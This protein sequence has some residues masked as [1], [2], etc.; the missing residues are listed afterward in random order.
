MVE[1]ITAEGRVA[2]PPVPVGYRDR[3]WRITDHRTNL[4]FR[5]PVSGDGHVSYDILYGGKPFSV[6]V[7]RVAPD[8]YGA[9]VA[10][11]SH[12]LL[13]CVSRTGRPT[14]KMLTH[15]R[16]AAVS[17]V[18]IDLKHGKRH[19]IVN[20][21]AERYAK[22]M[23]ALCEAKPVVNGYVTPC[24]NCPPLL[25]PNPPSYD[26]FV[27]TADPKHATRLDWMLCC[28][29]FADRPKRRETEVTRSAERCL[30][31]PFCFGIRPGT[32]LCGGPAGYADTEEM[33]SDMERKT[34]AT[35][36][37]F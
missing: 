10:A 2:L 18:L 34:G 11:G 15:V 4:S 27:K 13:L 21:A 29:R 25:P 1:R 5:R 30:H 37:L 31:C 20:L 32:V 19:W 8:L 33:L 23:L 22:G 3:P 9:R 14:D 6:P 26:E 7:D 36:L 24:V 16:N 35:R 12:E 28:E 17:A